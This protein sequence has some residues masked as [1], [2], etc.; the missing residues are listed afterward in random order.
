MAVSLAYLRHM[1]T[2]IAGYDGTT[3][4]DSALDLA[5]RLAE[6]S[7]ARVVAVNVY[8]G[9]YTAY[10]VP[11]EA[12]RE[13]G[14][15]DEFRERAQTLLRELDGRGVETRA[16]KDDSPARGLCDLARETGA[17]LIAVGATR[18]GRVGRLAPGSVGMHLLHGAPCPV[19]VAPAGSGDTPVRT[20]GV[21]YD[22]REESRAALHAARELATSHHAELVVVGVREQTPIAVPMGD[23]R[24]PQ[25]VEEADRQFEATLEHAASTTDATYR[26][27]LGDPGRTLVDLSGDFDLLV[28][29]SRGRGPVGSVILGSISR[30][31]VD[32]ASCP[33]LVVPRPG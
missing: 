6:P 15:E 24:M 19:L 1:T 25:L 32:H 16:V 12:V 17:R 5:L 20:I 33:V 10:W 11:V 28:T 29:G 26:M 2:Y 7:K 23:P 14:L 13:G 9:A 31:L 22:D 21:A 27:H 4:S 30:R 18:H 8:P 3:E